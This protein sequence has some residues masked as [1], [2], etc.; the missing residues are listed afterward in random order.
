LLT[1][2]RK[3]GALILRVPDGLGRGAN[4]STL[5]GRCIGH[6]SAN[7]VEIVE[8]IKCKDLRC[9]NHEKCEA[10]SFILTFNQFYVSHG[11]FSTTAIGFTIFLVVKVIS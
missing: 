5:A 10:K 1:Q 3:G 4:S 6:C 2:G 8:A 11:G 9:I 7:T